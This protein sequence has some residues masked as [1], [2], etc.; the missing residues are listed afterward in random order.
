MAG[1]KLL[2]VINHPDWFWSHRLPLAR[3]AR[4]KGW[5][6]AVAMHGAEN[7]E[8]LKAEEFQAISLSGGGSGLSV[9]GVFKTINELRRVIGRERPEIVHAITL[10]YAFM[11]GIAARFYP[12]VRVVHTIAG[13]GYLFS[14]NGL[15]PAILRIMIAPFLKFALKGDKFRIIFQNQDDMD[16]MIS[17]GFVNKKQAYLIRGSGVDINLFKPCDNNNDSEG[18]SEG[19]T[20]EDILPVVLMPTRLVHDKGVGVFI[21]AAKILKARGVVARFQIAGGITRNNPLAISE[22]EMIEM[23]KGGEVEWLGKVKD[24]PG[25]LAR[26]TIIAYPSY[27]REGVPKVLLEAAAAGKAIVTTDHVGCRDAVRDGE[28]GLL[29]PVKNAP[30]LADAIMKLL[31]DGGLRRK[32]ERNSRMRAIKEFDVN[33]IVHQTLQVYDYDS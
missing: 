1:K 7:D 9:I 26:A 31:S 25:L 4:D 5:D 29:V 14:G 10:K 20:G 2:Y 23:T 6:V 3:G 27:Y 12:K 16:L 19:E 8:R 17:R 18:D 33:L 11:T 22:K 30:A 24:M 28:N 32:M 13:L 15:K 21:E